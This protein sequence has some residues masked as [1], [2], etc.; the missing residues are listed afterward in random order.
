MPQKTAIR[1]F[2]LLLVTLTV[3]YLCWQLLSQA[4]T[5]PVYYYAR[6]IEFLGILLFIALAL[7]I[8]M[9]FEE[10]GILVP[11]GV[12]FRSLL[13]SGGVSVAVIGVSAL[14]LTWQTGKP[15]AALYVKGNVSRLTYFLVAPL[16]ELLAKGVMYYAFELTLEKRHPHVAN[17]LSALTFALFHVMYGPAMMLLSAALCLGT[18]LLFQKHRCV[19][20]CA[21]AHLSIGLFYD[22][23]AF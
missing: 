11:R 9:R 6:L 18:G 23:F 16:Q 13:L 4:L 8:P 19:W 15:L 2:S 12:L 1:T 21:L 20:G 14:L 22:C 3:Y 10:M 17:A 5:L 7:C